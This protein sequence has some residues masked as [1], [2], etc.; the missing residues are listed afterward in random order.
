MDQDQDNPSMPTLSSAPVVAPTPATPQPS[1]TTPMPVA[2]STVGAEYAGV[3][4]RWLANIIDSLVLFAINVPI[5]IIFS[6]VGLFVGKGDFLIGILMWV[7]QLVIQSAIAIYYYGAYQHKNG[8]TIGRKAMH[9]KTVLTVD[10]T[11]PSAGKFVTREFVFKLIS[12]L[13]IIGYPMAIFDAKKQALH[14]KLAGTVVI[15]V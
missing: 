13:T 12:A 1:V 11:T 2:T 8:Q 10:G 6:L 7:V 5:F 4:S 3:L 14:D 15:K 9:V